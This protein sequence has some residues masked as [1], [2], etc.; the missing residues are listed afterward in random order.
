MLLTLALLSVLHAAPSA[1]SIAG[2]W[3]ITGDVVGNAVKTTCTIIQSSSA[4]TGNCTNAEGA[5]Y[6]LT[7]EVKEGK[8]TFQYDIDWQGQPLTVIYSATV[9]KELKGVIDV[10]PVGATGTFTAVP[11]PATP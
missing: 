9:A 6:V 3:Q 7:G 8:V 5:P 10:K 11:V 4:L 1:D 2:K